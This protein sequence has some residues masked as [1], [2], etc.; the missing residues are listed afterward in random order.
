MSRNLLS[1][2][3]LFFILIILFTNIMVYPVVADVGLTLQYYYDNNDIAVRNCYAILD[4][5]SKYC[6]RDNNYLRVNW[7]SNN[8]MIWGINYGSGNALTSILDIS[9]TESLVYSV[10][11]PGSLHT[12]RANYIQNATQFKSKNTGLSASVIHH[13]ISSS[14]DETK[15]GFNAGS[16]CYVWDLTTN[17]ITRTHNNYNGAWF[18]K[19]KNTLDYFIYNSTHFVIADAVTG[20]FDVTRNISLTI[21]WLSYSDR[22]IADVCYKNTYVWVCWYNKSLISDNGII[23]VDPSDFTIA[24]DNLTGYTP[25]TDD[26]EALVIDVTNDDGYII[27]GDDDGGTLSLIQTNNDVALGT[28]YTGECYGRFSNGNSYVIVQQNGI[29]A[30]S[31]S[32]D[33]W[34]YQTEFSPSEEETEK[35]TIYINLY[36]AQTREKLNLISGDFIGPIYTG[37]RGD[38][39]SSLTNNLQYCFYDGGD[40]SQYGYGWPIQLDLYFT[41]GSYNWLNISHYPNLV[42][43]SGGVS[44]T[45]YYNYSTFMQFYDEQIYSIYLERIDS[46]VDWFTNGKCVKDLYG[47][48]YCLHT[49][50]DLYNYGETIYIRYK[51]PKLPLK[52][53][54]SNRLDPRQIGI[55]GYNDSCPW[56]FGDNGQNAVFM[57][58]SPDN[59]WSYTVPFGDQSQLIFDGQYHVITLPEYWPPKY[60]YQLIEVGIFEQSAPILYDERYLHD[61]YFTIAGDPFTA[62]GNITSVSPSEPKIGQLTNITFDAN[63]KGSLW[64]RIIGDPDNERYLL[65]DFQYLNKP[66][67]SNLYIER[68]FYDFGV[69]ILELDVYDGFYQETVDTKLFW[70]NATMETPGGAGYN[71]EFL[72]TIPRYVVAGY[73]VVKVTYRTKKD[74]TA[75]LIRDPVGQITRY[76]TSVN[77]GVGVY[78]FT[79]PTYAEI[80]NWNITMNGTDTLYSGFNVIADENNY[81]DFT[82]EVFTVEES[83][84]FVISHDKRVKLI[85]YK[86]NKSVG[87]PIFLEDFEFSNSLFTVSLNYVKPEVG[88]YKVEMWQINNYIQIRKL[89]EDNCRVIKAPVEK[90]TDSGYGNF[91]QMLA[92]GGEL[93]GGETYGLAFLGLLLI[94]VVTVMLIELKVKDDTI[95]LIDVGLMLY[96]VWLGW[97]PIWLGLISIV[98]A[99]LLFGE[100][101]TKKLKI[102][103]KK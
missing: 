94:I 22:G 20:L 5:A 98:I 41:P 87:I 80:G 58:G 34:I 52:I 25:Y 49:N 11:L 73:D 78:N 100:A 14:Y 12:L 96:L 57:F 51:L 1:T 74:N 93:F 61:V 59:F 79:L 40:C 68:K 83:F 97:L 44:V 60:Q 67:G 15:V 102:G 36:D 42:G 46:G 75:I 47:E 54:P 62:S 6:I 38:I 81:I 31:S 70:I 18:P 53:G 30:S 23:G 84:S 76:S 8:T 95:F 27:V 103:G 64:F 65:T 7:V 21:P 99:G 82:K 29:D 32:I 69:Y 91:W 101:F 92:L 86:D 16:N 26:G 55:W 66:P 88:S 45:T 89:A 13:T 50:K 9:R 39:Y 3:F 19:F 85:F 48:K 24:V 71:V 4:N 28:G 37:V 17:A 2:L 35:S 56:L 77:T 63:N 90:I 72:E 33:P 10:G 43:V